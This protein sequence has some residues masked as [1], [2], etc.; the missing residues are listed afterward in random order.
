M[1]HTAHQPSPKFKCVTDARCAARSM[2][3]PTMSSSVG[4]WSNTVISL[5]SRISRY[6][7]I[8]F[9]SSC[10]TAEW[11]TSDIA[12]GHSNVLQRLEPLFDGT[13]EQV[14]HP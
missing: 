5:N 11:H 3:M 13:N 4:I 7:L 2:P 6:K 10:Q 8:H 14:H 1:R 12:N 9:D